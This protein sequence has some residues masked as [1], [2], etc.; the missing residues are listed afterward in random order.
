MENGDSKRDSQPSSRRDRRAKEREEHKSSAKVVP[1]STRRKFIKAVTPGGWIPE[2]VRFAKGKQKTISRPAVVSAVKDVA[3][4]GGIPLAINLLGSAE[5]QRNQSLKE[6]VVSFTWKDAD[7]PEKLK[8]FLESL[9]DGYLLYTNSTHLTKPDLVEKTNFIK[10]EKE[11]INVVK[12][13]DP[14][15][16]IEHERGFADYE[17]K[18]AFLNL[19]A[20]KR[21][22]PDSAGLEIIGTLWHEWLHLDLQPRTQGQYINN[23]RVLLR[24]STN[25]PGEIIRKY[26]GGKML[27]EN[28]NDYD[29]FEEVWVE[30]LA[31]KL[32]RD[33]LGLSEIDS[34]RDYYN[35]GVDILLPLTDSIPFQEMYNMHAT[36]DF[37]GFATRIGEKL[38]GNQPPFNRGEQLFIAL[39]KADPDLIRQTGVLNQIQR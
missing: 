10:N 35:N 36:S 23:P 38:P 21:D 14:K 27:S 37:E 15:Y 33:L 17:N 25:M 28:Y 5:P 30:T 32:Q 39:H 34:S 29:R 16:A 11:F 20:L 2:A 24:P 8:A 31:V 18:R 12:E 7:N 26:Y 13:I 4:I 3:L 9:V 1:T 22:G 6:K 19:E